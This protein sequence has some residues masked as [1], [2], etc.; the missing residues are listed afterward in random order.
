MLDTSLD[1]DRIIAWMAQ[2]MWLRLSC[3]TY[4]EYL[5]CLDRCTRLMDRQ[6]VV[7]FP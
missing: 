3:W 5:Y 2:S 7:I 1:R 4:D 6:K